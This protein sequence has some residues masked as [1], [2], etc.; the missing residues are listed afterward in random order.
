MLARDPVNCEVRI[1]VTPNAFLDQRAGRVGLLPRRRLVL[2]DVLGEGVEPE[3][4][5]PFWVVL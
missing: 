2:D 4:A 5:C 3:H 1:I